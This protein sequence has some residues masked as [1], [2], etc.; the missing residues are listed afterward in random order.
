[1]EFATITGGSLRKPVQIL[2]QTSTP[3]ASGQPLA[4]W[5]VVRSPFAAIT[6]L[7]ADE[8]YQ[9]GQVTSKVSH[10]ITVRWSSFVL[11]P[12]MRVVFGSRTF[13]VQAVNNVLERNSIVRMLCLEID[14]STDSE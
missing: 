4:A 9:A 5:S 12:G 7:S 8:P 1:M 11:Q 3:D 6:D 14:G 2:Q 13:L 10:L